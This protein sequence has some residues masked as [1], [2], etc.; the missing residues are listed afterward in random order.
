[1]KKNRKKHLISRNMALA[2]QTLGVLI[3]IG[4]SLLQ[5]MFVFSRGTL[6]FYYGAAF[7]TLAFGVLERRMYDGD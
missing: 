4:V 1:M 2:F 3:F 5:C 7:A 6:I